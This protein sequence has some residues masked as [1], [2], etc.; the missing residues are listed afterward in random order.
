VI[1]YLS[2]V[3]YDVG[4]DDIQDLCRI[5]RKITNSLMRR[6]ARWQS[7]SATEALRG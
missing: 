3:A 1:S 5:H 2:S 7:D 4:D 6:N